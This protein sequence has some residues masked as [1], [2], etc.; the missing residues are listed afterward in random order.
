VNS[1]IF[2]CLLVLSF[3]SLLVSP[4]L[5]ALFILSSCFVSW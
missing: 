2:A 1:L 3:L 5:I 4:C